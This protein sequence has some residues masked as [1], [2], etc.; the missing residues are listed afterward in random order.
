M[1]SLEPTLPETRV[2]RCPFRRSE[3]I[4]PESHVTAF[5]WVI[6]VEYRCEACSIAFWFVTVER[7]S[8]RTLGRWWT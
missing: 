7:L 5:S 3:R 4:A 2:R 8:R 6:K 1:P